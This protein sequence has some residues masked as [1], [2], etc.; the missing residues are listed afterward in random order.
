MCKIFLFPCLKVQVGGLCN[1]DSY[2]STDIP[3]LHNSLI[4]LTLM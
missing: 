4:Q 3:G 1:P 2:S